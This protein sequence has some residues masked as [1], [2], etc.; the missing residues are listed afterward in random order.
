MCGHTEQEVKALR[1]WLQVTLALHSTDAL[2]RTVLGPSPLT[3][4]L[5]VYVWLKPRQSAS[6]SDL[7]TTCKLDNQSKLIHAIKPLIK[8]GFAKRIRI[9][10]DWRSRGLQLLE[11]GRNA[12][13]RL[14][15]SAA[16][17]EPP[18]R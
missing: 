11:P 1:A 7:R 2:A 4:I 13:A 12:I 6:Y 14:L 9:E 5:L 17:N 16:A 18:P 15:S 3:M 8:R 10:N